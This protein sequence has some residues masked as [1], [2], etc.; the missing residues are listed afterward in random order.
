M[1]DKDLIEFEIKSNKPGFI[2]E[3]DTGAIGEAVARIGGGRT[4]T[5]DAIDHAVGYA[6]ERKIGD[7]VREKDVL[8]IL[9][10]RNEDQFQTVRE[11]LLNA[12][13]ISGANNLNQTL[14]IKEVIRQ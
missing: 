8:G 10:C 1:F 3:I 2:S 4:K 13:K 11:K 12:Y 7:E 14:L 9:S 5:E 6:C